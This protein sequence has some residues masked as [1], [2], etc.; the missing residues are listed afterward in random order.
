MPI[1]R[2]KG[3]SP[4]GKRESDL[5]IAFGEKQAIEK[6]QK[7]G[8]Q[9]VSVTDKSDSLEFRFLSLLNPVKT[10]DLVVFFR[11]FSIMISANL[12]LV[13]SLKVAGEQ[14][15]NLTLKM[16]VSEI[17][18]EVDGGERLSEAMSKRPKI[19]PQFHVSVI[20]SGETAG[21]LDEVLNYLADEMERNYDMMS[22]VKGA[23][24]Y[25]AVI[26][27]GLLGIGILMMVMV[28]P[29]IT[30]ILVSS[31]ASIPWPTKV[32]IAISDFL[33]SF[34]WLVVLII[35]V[36]I[37]GIRAASRHKLTKR[38]I[39]R[40]K[41]KLPVF[42]KLFQYIYLVRFAR[43]NKTLVLG[44]VQITK[45]LEIVADIVDNEIYKET[46]KEAA[47]NVK[48]GSTMSGVFLKSEFIPEMVAHMVSVGERTGKLSLVLDK[49]SDFYDRELSNLTNNLMSLLEPL[50][51]LV[52]GLGVGIMV[53][54]VLLPMYSAATQM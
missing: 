52:M 12:P 11:Q 10:K 47:E 9:D 8:L 26:F 50:I 31:N 28:V 38:Y 7:K 23:M 6:A 16:V 3:K 53:A 37:G 21:K 43:S 17:A 29:K 33:T 44:G 34:W 24:I 5:V 1:F 39:D 25:P 42:G 14:T 30:E 35:V 22:K 45:S 54:A 32:I 18:Q 41:L 4:A 15:D 19:F 40:I 2:Y 13:Q 36:L 27:M 20:R 46:F 51:V 49:I 48:K